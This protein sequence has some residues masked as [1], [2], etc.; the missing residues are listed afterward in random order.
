MKRND[1]NECVIDNERDVSK[2]R[3]NKLVVRLNR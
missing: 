1:E 2:D 3:D